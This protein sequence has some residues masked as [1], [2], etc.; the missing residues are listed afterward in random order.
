MWRVCRMLRRLGLVSTPFTKPPPPPTTTSYFY[1]NPTITDKNII[2]D[3]KKTAAF[4]TNFFNSPQNEKIF[5][6]PPVVNNNH[7]RCD[8]GKCTTTIDIRL[9][10]DGN[11]VILYKK[12]SPITINDNDKK[13]TIYPDAAT[14]IYPVGNQQPVTLGGG[15]R[16]NRRT[17]TKKVRRTKRRQTKKR[18]GSK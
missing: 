14:S 10:G 4:F 8:N 1:H 16:R 15:K 5:S 18:R 17:S 12:G 9:Y 11:N 3:Q 7:Y 2:F 13:A 6:I